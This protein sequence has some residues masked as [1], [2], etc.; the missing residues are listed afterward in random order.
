[1]TDMVQRI[2][3]DRYIHGLRRSALHGVGMSLLFVGS[4]IATVVALGLAL[5]LMIAT[6]SKRFQRWQGKRQAELLRTVR[7]RA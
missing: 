2:G 3:T 5:P 4:A 7:D 1:M 6:R